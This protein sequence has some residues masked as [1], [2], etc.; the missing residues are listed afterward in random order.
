V[1]AVA[2]EATKAWGALRSVD[3]GRFRGLSSRVGEAFGAASAGE[4]WTSIAEG[5]AAGRYEAVLPLLLEHNAFVMRARNGSDPW[6]RVVNGRLDVRFRDEASE[7]AS[8]CELPDLWRNNY[9]LNPL[10]EV[11]VTLGKAA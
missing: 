5:L 11:V 4:V 10:K 1:R 8:R 2:V 3:A 7:L 6:V 9:F